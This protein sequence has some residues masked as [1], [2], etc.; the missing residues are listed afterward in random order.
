MRVVLSWMT[1]VWTAGV[2]WGDVGEIRNTVGQPP[3]SKPVLSPPIPAEPWAQRVI[4]RG[5]AD[6]VLV[7]PAP[8]TVVEWAHDIARLRPLLLVV[9]QERAITNVPVVHIWDSA[10]QDWLRIASQQFVTG[11]IFD[12]PPPHAILVGPDHLLPPGMSQKPSWATKLTRIPR[13][14]L[15]SMVNAL[16]EIFSFTPSE[17]RA[18]AERYGFTLRDLNEERRRWGR[19]GRPGEGPP[20]PPPVPRGHDEMPPRSMPTPSPSPLSEDSPSPASE[21][22]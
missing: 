11:A 3:E 14:D 6:C 22:K 2:C 9:Y 7:V 16:N 21:D 8:P 10:S 15:V 4:P 5:R 20:P 1:L 17:W 12:R 13:V 19:Y 18:L